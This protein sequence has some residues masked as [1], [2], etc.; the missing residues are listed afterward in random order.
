MTKERSKK[1]R[2]IAP[3]F[4]QTNLNKCAKDDLSIN[5]ICPDWLAETWLNWL[6]NTVLVELL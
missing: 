2:I 4:P 5:D 1:Y 3:M 6:K